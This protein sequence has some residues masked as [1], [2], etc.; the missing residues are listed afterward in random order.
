[1]LIQLLLASGGAVYRTPLTLRVLELEQYPVDDVCGLARGS[2]LSQWCGTFYLDGLEHC[3]KRELKIRG[4]LRY[5]NNFVLFSD[6]RSQLVKARGVIAAWL[7]EE[8]QVRLHP[9]RW[10]VLS[11]AHPIRARPRAGAQT[12]GSSGWRI[13]RSPHAAHGGPLLRTNS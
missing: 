3:V 5:V 13:A 6:N 10:D 1:V 2:Y 11:N 7:A 9:K 8:R 4:C 12:A